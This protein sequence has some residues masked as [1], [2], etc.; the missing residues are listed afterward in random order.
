L[1]PNI[2]PSFEKRISEAKRLR[3]EVDP[4]KVKKI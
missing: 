2:D 1:E 3:A 4:P